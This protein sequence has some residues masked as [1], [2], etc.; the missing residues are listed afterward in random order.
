MKNFYKNKNILVT[1]GAGF[2]GSHI[3]QK[4]CEY[5]AH[6][7]IIDDLSTG[8][9]DN[10]KT[11]CSRINFLAR[12]ITSYKTCVKATKNKDLVFH[13]AAFVSVPESIKQPAL[14]EKINVEGTANLLEASKIN[15]VKTFVFSSS[16]AIYGE[17]NGICCESDTPSPQSPYAQSK[18]NGE[19]LCKEY[20]QNFKLNTA[21][22]RYFNVYGDRQNYA[23]EYSGVVAKFKNNILQQQPITIYG[24]GEQRRDFVHVSQAVKANLLLGTM[25]SCPGEIFNIASGNSITLLELISQLEKETTK[26]TTTIVFKPAR[27]GDIFCSIAN[28]K[29]YGTFSKKLEISKT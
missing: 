2:I 1:G 14:C 26:K 16:A 7:T 28:C 22:L 6:V 12:D 3:A 20:S 25:P 8:S 23:S 29:K 10:I 5:G 21:C 24:T 9:L 15:R 4:L 18:L 11:F 27:S 13:L 19:L 17:K